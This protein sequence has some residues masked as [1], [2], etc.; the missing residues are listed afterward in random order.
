MLERDNPDFGHLVSEGNE[1]VRCFL[2]QLALTVA[3]LFSIVIF[4]KGRECCFDV[5]TCI[6][7][8][9]NR[10]HDCRSIFFILSIDELQFN[11]HRC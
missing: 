5:L 9:H 4:V 1:A 7:V 10:K 8:A 2:F 3:K 11:L 6:T